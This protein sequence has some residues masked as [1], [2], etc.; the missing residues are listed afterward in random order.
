VTR[1]GDDG[2]RTIR[3]EALKTTVP[4]E[5]LR[6]IEVI[7]AALPAAEAEDI[8][9]DLIQAHPVTSVKRRAAVLLAEKGFTRAAEILDASLR[10]AREPAAR[11]GI[12][13]ALGHL[14][15]GAG[16]PA[17]LDLAG[18]R[19]ETDDLRAAA[20]SAL[21]R[22]GLPSAVPVLLELAARP[23]RGL[24]RLLRS[25]PAALRAAA[26]KALGAF[27]NVETAFQALRAAAA[28]DP[29]PAVRAAAAAALLPPPRPAPA[30]PAVQ[31]APAALSGLLSDM[32]LETLCQT[33]SAAQRSGTLRVSGDEV[34][35][36]VYFDRGQVV[37]VSLGHHK[38]V[39]AFRMLVQIDS[40]AFSFR[41]G[42][43][44]PE[45]RMTMS[46]QKLLLEALGP[47]SG[48]DVPRAA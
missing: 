13:E 34:Q 7:P 5:A 28:D 23:A 39:E 27:P 3:E 29:E 6:L 42:E 16:V 46:V 20:C 8:L 12:V 4:S 22:S 47:P 41:A 24:T 36:F 9:R 32:P 43:L 15:E 48:P 30:A 17:L 37:A 14:K 1:L 44:P 10:E 26:V 19:S 11:A 45:R 35:G 18:S 38:D 40:G 31:A 21:A 25:T 33:L 2:I